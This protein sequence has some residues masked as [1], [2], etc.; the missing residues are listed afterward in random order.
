MTE[1][2]RLK[3]EFENDFKEVPNHEYGKVTPIMREFYFGKKGHYGDDIDVF[4]WYHNIDKEVEPLLVASN[5]VEKEVAKQSKYNRYVKGV[6]IDVY[7]VLKAFEVTNPATQHAIKKLLAGGKRGY[8][9][10]KQDY[11]EAIDSI[12]RAIE[13]E[14]YMEGQ[15][16][17][18]V[19]FVM[20][21]YGGK[22]MR[23]LEWDKDLHLEVVNDRFVFSWRGNIQ[24]AELSH[25][26]IMG[27][28][29]EVKE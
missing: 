16:K 22:K 10:T 26:D 27:S 19:A 28:W 4:N 18:E 12:Y 24:D 9:N 14:E 15:V 23:G 13:L 17:F 6:W 2:E 29:K 1:Q 5:F 25:S 21:R 8:K 3:Q 7:D 20:M 11:N